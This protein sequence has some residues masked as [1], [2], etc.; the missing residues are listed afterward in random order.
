MKKILVS[1]AAA[2]LAMI[3]GS[4]AVVAQEQEQAE[5]RTF[6]PVEVWVCNYREGKGQADYDRAIEAL[7]SVP[8]ADPPAS[9]LAFRL[10]RGFYGP[11][12]DFDFVYLGVWPDGGS[13]MGRDYDNYVAEGSDANDAWNDAVDC[14]AASMF[15]S[16]NVKPPPDDGPPD[17]FLI[18]AS[19]CDVAEGANTGDAI[20]AV[21]AWGQH[22]TEAGSEGGT[23]IWFQA[24]GGG[25]ADFDFK[26][27]NSHRNF[28]AFGDFF[29]WY[30]DSAAYRKWG[31][32]TDGLLD[33]DDARVYNSETL[34]NNQFE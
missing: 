11:D 28:Q 31:E 30:A 23:W 20:D 1:V 27:M 19:D 29:Q 6:V 22:R 3:F 5:I 17:N 32:L 8:A 18:T 24:F 4:G 16:T 25:D 12:Q 9:Y 21:E 34:I 13:S 15:A 7:R 33:C 26:I 2:M 14:E 10:T